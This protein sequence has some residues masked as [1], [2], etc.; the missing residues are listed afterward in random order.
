MWEIKAFGMTL[1]LS[2]PASPFQVIEVDDEIAFRVA[3]VPRVS[4]EDPGDRIYRRDSGGS[5]F[6]VGK[7]RFED[8]EHD[9]AHA[10]LVGARRS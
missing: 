2:D 5:W 6:P 3:S 9:V 1:R 4:N 10:Y 8:F 7:L